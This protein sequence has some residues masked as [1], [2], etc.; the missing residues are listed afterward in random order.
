MKDIDFIARNW[1]Y[2]EGFLPH[3]FFRSIIHSYNEREY[4]LQSVNVLPNNSIE[5]TLYSAWAG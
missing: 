5:I 4:I 3:N 1:L 2:D